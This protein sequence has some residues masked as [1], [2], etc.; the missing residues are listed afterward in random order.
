MSR[1][2]SRQGA[3]SIGT[4]NQSESIYFGRSRPSSAVSP[5]QRFHI[6]D[7]ALSENSDDSDSSASKEIA[8]MVLPRLGSATLSGYKTYFNPSRQLSLLI[9]SAQSSPLNIHSYSH[10]AAGRNTA[11]HSP[12]LAHRRDSVEDIYKH[13]LLG[14]LDICIV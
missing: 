10:V 1:G 4:S 5:T 6:I 11:V 14:C 3:R 7:R 12:D 9:H 2:S 8:E 13:F